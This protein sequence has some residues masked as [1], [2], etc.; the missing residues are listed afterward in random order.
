LGL[1]FSNEK[2]ISF[3]NKRGKKNQRRFSFEK[4][5]Q[6]GWALLL[7]NENETKRMKIRKE[8]LEK[9]KN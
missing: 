3:S 2:K 9:R 6:E 5:L 1:L 4:P 7:Q 8:T